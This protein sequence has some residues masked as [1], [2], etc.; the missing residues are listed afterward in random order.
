MESCIKVDCRTSI[1]RED[2]RIN[3]LIINFIKINHKAIYLLR[4][5]R[6]DMQRQV[7]MQRQ[8]SG[9]FGM[10]KLFL[11]PGD[12]DNDKYAFGDFTSELLDCTDKFPL[13]HEIIEEILNEKVD[14]IELL[15]YLNE[16]A[17]IFFG[18]KFQKQLGASE[19][20][21]KEA[22][23]QGLS[24]SIKNMDEYETSS[25]LAI[26]EA[27]CY[28]ILKGWCNNEYQRAYAQIMKEVYAL[29]KRLKLTEF[30]SILSHKPD[31]EDA[32]NV[33]Q[34]IESTDYLTGTEFERLVGR[35]LIADGFTVFYTN[36]GSDQGVDIVAQK[37][38]VKIAVQTKRYTGKVSN[39]AVQEIVAG[40]THYYCDKA[41]LVTNSYF[42]NA[43]ISLA[44]SNNVL[45]WDRDL[46]KSRLHQLVEGKR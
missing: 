5:G 4:M 37:E 46:L 34:K 14:E 27:T 13:L 41:L 28:F 1:L 20:D 30:K 35:I 11:E 7:N 43:A 44:I 22:L 10:S 24:Q 32:A 3:P 9:A 40:K 17:T 42:T 38:G 39:S 12:L 33:V 16:K 21:D 23:L 25:F 36:A 26:G 45:L 15:N 18:E 2:S 8:T 6:L 29:Q 19:I 31:D